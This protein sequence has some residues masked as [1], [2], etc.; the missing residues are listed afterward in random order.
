MSKLK[1][2]ATS[3]IRFFKQHKVKFVPHP[4]PYED[5]GGT[6]A[7]A[8]ALSID[9]FS[10]IKTLVMEDDEQHPF[11]ILM[12]GSS[13]VSLKHLARQLKVK[14][15]TP[16]VPAKADR[17]TGYQTGGISPFGTRQPLPVY[18]EASI[19]QLEKI[20]INGGK[21]GL[22]VEISPAD[23]VRTLQPVKVSVAI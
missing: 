8:K 15:V 7:S 12:H 21:R 19:E 4:Y 2:P 17:I 14:Q 16:C 5:K 18:M 11:I 3:A 20:W 23:L 22:L 9:E 1:I 10:V 6:K 13:E